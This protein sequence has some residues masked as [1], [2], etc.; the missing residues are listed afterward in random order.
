MVSTREHPLQ[1][2]LWSDFT[3]R[4]KREY[5]YRVVAIRGQPGALVEGE[6]VEVRITTENEDRDTHA[7][8]FNRGVAGSQ[9]YTRKFGDRRPDE[10]PNR[11]AWRWLSRGLF[12]AML[13]FVGKARGPNSAVR[14][15]VYEFNQG[16]VLQAFAKAPRFGCRCPNYLR[17][18]SDS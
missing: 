8:Y 13:D 9:A 2:F 17:R 14:A 15:A 12:E 4:N 10:V 6:N 3:V 11:E 5:T 1:T 16:A 18:T 7:I